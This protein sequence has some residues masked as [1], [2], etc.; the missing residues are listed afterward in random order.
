MSH[1]SESLSF[2]EPAPLSD[3]ENRL[4]KNKLKILTNH[5]VANHLNEGG[6]FFEAEGDESFAESGQIHIVKTDSSSKVISNK[7]HPYLIWVTSKYMERFYG[8]TLN[9]FEFTKKED[10]RIPNFYILDFNVNSLTRKNLSIVMMFMV[11]AFQDKFTS[12]EKNKVIINR[13]PLIIN[14]GDK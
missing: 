12:T 5:L 8:K 3:A 10:T 11:V 2:S 4:I 1:L 14:R 7:V 9:L 13:L 6:Y